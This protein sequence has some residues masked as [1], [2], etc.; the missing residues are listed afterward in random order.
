MVRYSV[1]SG[2]NIH[3]ASVTN[4]TSKN[5][6][7]AIHNVAIGSSAGVCVS[8]DVPSTPAMMTGTVIG[9]NRI[10]S[11]TSRV[12]DRISIAA[13]SVPTARKPDRA[14]HEQRQ[15]VQRPREQ[16]RLEQKRHH[17]HQQQLGQRQQR[18]DPEQLA[19]VDRR[20][21]RRRQQQRAHRFAV[22][23]ALERPSERQVAGEDDRDPQNADRRRP[24]TGCPSLTNANENTR[25]HATAKNSVV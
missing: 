2:S 1:I 5:T 8:A 10:G 13:N 3:S 23:L 21:R 20:P 14:E 7:S 18:D 24:P 4:T 17:R 15:Q 19:D 12:R 9:Y 11:S 6:S 16:R 22:A 25:T